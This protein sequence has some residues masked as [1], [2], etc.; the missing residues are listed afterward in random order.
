MSAEP[1]WWAE[2]G[3]GGLPLGQCFAGTASI[4]RHGP[5]SNPLYASVPSIANAGQLDVKP[6]QS[7][8]RAWYWHW[9]C[10]LHWPCPWLF[11]L[12]WWPGE[13][14]QSQAREHGH[15]AHCWIWG[16]LGC[17]HGDYWL[18]AMCLFLLSMPLVK[19]RSI[20]AFKC[21]QLV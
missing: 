17:P 16:I 6:S 2:V 18:S 9:H 5:V 15:E 19:S 20:T 4:Y 7:A 14:W 8:D 13:A 1:H 10:F 11:V 3:G 21:I 12:Y